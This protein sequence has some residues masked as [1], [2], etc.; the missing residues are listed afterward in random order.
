MHPKLISGYGRTVLLTI[1]SIGLLSACRPA[2]SSPVVQV[3]GEG[4]KVQGG[5]YTNVTPSELDTMLKNKDFILVNVHIPFEGKIAHTDLSIPYDQISQEA[6]KLPVD[7]NAKILVYCRSG[8]MSDIAAKTL[9]KLGYTNIWNLAGGMVA[10]EN[11]GL[12]I[13]H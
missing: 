1:I 6:S 2:A 12:P 10:W 9:I 5:A 4:V 7:K 13:E 11:A 3:V 8:H